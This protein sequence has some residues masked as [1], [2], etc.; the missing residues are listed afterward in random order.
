MRAVQ[1]GPAAGSAAGWAAAGPAG[2]PP[3]P[4]TEEGAAVLLTLRGLSCAWGRRACQEA[5][6]QRESFQW[7][8]DEG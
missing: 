2:P 6:S 3:E 5:F 4:G 8:P 7:R 1:R